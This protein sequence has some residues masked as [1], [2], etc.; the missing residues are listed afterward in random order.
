M[1]LHQSQ[2]RH[3]IVM[4]IFSLLCHLIFF[5][6]QQ[7]NED[8]EYLPVN[9]VQLPG[10]WRDHEGARTFPVGP[11]I[12]TETMSLPVSAATQEPA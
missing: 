4:H 6:R 10:C 8:G 9:F 5:K 12:D 11:L 1:R 7:I 3:D 2:R